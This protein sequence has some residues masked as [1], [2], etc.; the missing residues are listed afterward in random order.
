MIRLP[1]ILMLLLSVLC[2]NAKAQ[3][4]FIHDSL[5]IN[6]FTS[7]VKMD[8]FSSFHYQLLA[9]TEFDSI[10]VSSRNRINDRA[11]RKCFFDSVGRISQFCM[12]IYKKGE[13][14]HWSTNYYSYED[15]VIECV[16]EFQTVLP[17]TCVSNRKTMSTELDEK[18]DYQV[19]TIFNNRGQRIS[20]GNVQ[21]FVRGENEVISVRIQDERYTYIY[22]KGGELLRSE[23]IPDCYNGYCPSREYAAFQWKRRRVK[24]L[25]ARSRGNAPPHYIEKGKSNFHRN[26][27]RLLK[28][29]KLDYLEISRF[30]VYRF[31]RK[32]YVKQIKEKTIKNGRFRTGLKTRYTY[33]R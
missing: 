9:R 27:E 2:L 30:V 1:S 26:E 29:Y 4:D 21:K 17:D 15:S 18:L 31:N 20:I 5:R 33:Y 6:C 3:N 12:E 7:P 19:F 24:S 16:Q 22:S 23:Q 32:G 25:V 13:L 8:V 14:I 28:K 11:K 10:I